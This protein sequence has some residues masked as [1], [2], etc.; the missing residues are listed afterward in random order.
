MRWVLVGMHDCDALGFHFDVLQL[1]DARNRSQCG[2]AE[3]KWKPETQD[4]APRRECSR[5]N[6]NN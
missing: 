1:G 2:G 6:K 5:G 4:H 3:L